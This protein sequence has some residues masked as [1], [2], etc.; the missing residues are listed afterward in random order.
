MIVRKELLMK[1]QGI[2]AS[3]TPEI[4]FAAASCGCFGC[5]YGCSGTVGM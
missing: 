5:G 2:V 3:F 4:A 1:A